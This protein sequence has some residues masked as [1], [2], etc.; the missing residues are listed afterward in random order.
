MRRSSIVAVLVVGGVVGWVWWW[1]GGEGEGGRVYRDGA[2]GCFWRLLRKIVS[3]LAILG[4]V[5]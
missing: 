4:N 5:V 3:W 2:R 1:R